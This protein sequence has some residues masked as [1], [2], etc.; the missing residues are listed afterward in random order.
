LAEF[1][2]KT[3]ATR[4]IQGLRITS[5]TVATRFIQGLRIT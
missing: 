1:I 2:T 3:L 5:K 4:F